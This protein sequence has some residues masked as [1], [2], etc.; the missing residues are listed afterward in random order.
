MEEGKEGGA[1]LGV[2]AKDNHIK[3]GALLNIPGEEKPADFAGRGPIVADYL[4]G[5]LNNFD[6]ADSL[7]RKHEQYN[8]FNFVS[9]HFKSV[10]EVSILMD[11]LILIYSLFQRGQQILPDSTRQQCPEGDQGF[12]LE[13]RSWI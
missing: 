7:F 6:Y 1:W 5:D 8:A 11:H 3:V 12:P 4:K 9:I 13:R 10:E 2:S